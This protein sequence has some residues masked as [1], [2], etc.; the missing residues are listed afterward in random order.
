MRPVGSPGQRGLREEA[1]EDRGP[2]GALQEDAASGE[3]QGNPAGLCREQGQEREAL[4]GQESRGGRP[5]SARKRT[6]LAGETTRHCPSLPEKPSRPPTAQGLQTPVEARLA[7]HTEGRAR[8][9]GD[10]LNSRLGE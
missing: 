1:W 5:S 10:D 3:K 9:D 2:A 8:S 4:R 6:P 7:T